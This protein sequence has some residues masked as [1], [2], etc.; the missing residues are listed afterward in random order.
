MPM[1]V[2]FAKALCITG[3][4][5][6][7]LYISPAAAEIGA[8]G[9]ITEIAV[10]SAP[11][12]CD[13]AGNCKFQITPTQLLAKAEAFVLSGQYDR[14]LPLIDALGQVPDI[15]M[16]QQFL[17]GYSAVETGDLKAAIC[18]WRGILED[19]P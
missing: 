8:D 12:Q 5:A 14:A 16:Q 6:V 3:G 11:P 9:A 18:N 19:S 7:S 4:L 13:S 15:W 1:P 17:T 10:P 2:T